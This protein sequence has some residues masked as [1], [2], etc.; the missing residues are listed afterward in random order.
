MQLAMQ[1]EVERLQLELQST[2]A[3]YKQVCQELVQAQN[4]VRV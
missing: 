4:Q 1:E 2:I 3:M